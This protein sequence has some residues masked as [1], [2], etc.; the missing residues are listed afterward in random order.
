MASS[1]VISVLSC[2]NQPALRLPPQPSAA[3]SSGLQHALGPTSRASQRTRPGLPT[4]FLFDYRTTL[5]HNATYIQLSPGVAS[6][7]SVRKRTWTTAK[8]VER[9]AWNVDYVDQSGTRRLK[10]FKRKKEADAWADS[11]GVAVREGTHVADSA[12]VTVKAAGDLWIKVAELGDDERYPLERTTVDQYKQHLRLHIEPFI[13]KK[14][15]SRITTPEVQ[16]FAS[17]LRANGRSPT[18]VKYVIRS[19][20]ALLTE[21]QGSGAVV[22]NAV[23]ERRRNRRTRKGVGKDKR[24]HAL[25]V[26]VDIPTPREIKALIGAAKGRYRLL[27]LTAIFTGLRASELRGLR[28]DDVDLNAA[29]LSVRQRADRFNQIGPPK[30]KAANRTVELTP[31]LAKDLREWKL[32]C[33]KKEDG[34]LDLVFPNG[35]GNVEFHVNIIL[36]GLIPTMIAAGVTKPVLN[37]DGRPVRD[38]EGK[39]VVEAK[40]SGL[41]ALRHFYASWCAKQGLSMKEVQVRMGHSNIAVTVDTYTHLFS[42]E[43]VTERLAEGERALLG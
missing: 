3:P 40:Y 17:T 42:D 6:I 29:K 4:G 31:E 11:T 15:L 16:R 37:A 19:L 21:A 14:K 22:R 12:S 35:A 13:G 18:M 24:G 7:M 38:D 28:W 9:E 32:K 30:T 10:T 36:R 20:G 1:I 43:T 25:D 2:L 27:L 26:G 23:S 34:K 39:P 5:Q 33:P 41:H 8:G